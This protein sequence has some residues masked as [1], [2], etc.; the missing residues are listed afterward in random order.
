MPL[1]VFVFLLSRLAAAESS[2]PRF[3]REEEESSEEEE[4]ELTPEEQGER[5]R[6][7]KHT[8]ASFYSL[9]IYLL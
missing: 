7:H 6:T 5:A 9:Y 8:H 2:E 4:E 1:S 3:M